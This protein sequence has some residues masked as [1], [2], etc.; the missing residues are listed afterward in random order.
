MQRRGELKYGGCVSRAAVFFSP[1][2]VQDNWVVY[3]GTGPVA[4]ARSGLDAQASDAVRVRRSRRHDGRPGFDAWALPSARLDTPRPVM[5]NAPTDIPVN[6]D[7]TY[8]EPTWGE[9]G[10][11]D[12]SGHEANGAGA[13]VMIGANDF[14]EPRRHAARWIRAMITRSVPSDAGLFGSFLLP[15][16]GGW[17]VSGGTLNGTLGASWVLV[18]ADDDGGVVIQYNVTAGSPHVFTASR[19]T[20]VDLAED[21]TAT[22]TAVANG[23]PEPAVAASSVRVWKVVTDGTEITSATTVLP[24]IPV[25]KDI[26]AN[27]LALTDLLAVGGDLDVTGNLTVGGDSTLGDDAGD[28]HTITG[29][30]DITGDTAITGAATIT[31]DLAVTGTTHAISG[32]TTITGSLTVAGDNPAVFTGNVTL[33]SA[34][35]DA[36]ISQGTTTFNAA[37]TCNSSLTVANGQTFTANGNSVIGN[38]GTDTCTMNAALTINEDVNFGANTITGA[39]G[40][41]TTSTVQASTVEPVVVN[42]QT[43]VASVTDGRMAYNGRRLT[44]G[45]GTAARLVHTPRTAYVVSETGNAAEDVAGASIQMEIEDTEWV[46]VRVEAMQTCTDN[47]AAP[48][49]RIRATNGVD[50]VTALNNGD[51]DVASL[52]LPVTTAVSQKRPVSFTVRWRPTNDEPTPDNTTWTLQVV[53]DV[54]AGSVTT[55]NV[56]LQAWYE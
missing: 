14:N 22:Y 28:S 49:I 50:N 2:D 5:P 47:G 10:S 11:F 54:T 8:R 45:D 3:A 12:P 40:T 46:F 16:S 26:A 13:G 52:Q 24:E 42:F 29:S 1:A 18:D 23:A 31:G 43:T 27:S 17:N 36:I 20:Y 15:G 33:G 44:L 53:H 6:V 41:I 56:F 34:S 48:T 30:V 37:V 35:G 9:G 21:G 19:D 55:S 7:G 4:V 51:N 39:G 32:S 25:F 38:A